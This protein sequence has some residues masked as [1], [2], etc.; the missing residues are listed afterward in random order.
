MLNCEFVCQNFPYAIDAWDP[1]SIQRR[2]HL[3]SH[4]IAILPSYISE[5][6]RTLK[7]FN[8]R[9]I[10]NV[11]S[12]E[13][14]VMKMAVSTKMTNVRL[15]DFGVRIR[16]LVFQRRGSATAKSIAPTG[17]TSR[18]VLVAS[19]HALPIISNAT[20]ADAFLRFKHL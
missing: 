2:V 15:V 11:E 12:V 16:R 13:F 7:V 10:Y 6:I 14:R 19:P 9:L 18:P 20:I 8:C 5:T 3:R 4:A 1:V 17:P